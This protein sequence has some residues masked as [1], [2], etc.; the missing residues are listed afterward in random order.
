MKSLPSAARVKLLNLR[1]EFVNLCANA[2]SA[3]VTSSNWKDRIHLIVMK[4]ALIVLGGFFL[5]KSVVSQGLYTGPS[6][7]RLLKKNQM[8]MGNYSRFYSS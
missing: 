3:K 2:L 1:A 6:T 7:I 8:L 4:A 5:A